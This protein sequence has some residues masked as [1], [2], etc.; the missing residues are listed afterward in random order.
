M[1]VNIYICIDVLKTLLKDLEKF[2]LKIKLLNEQLSCE[3]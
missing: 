2:I 1:L 3:F